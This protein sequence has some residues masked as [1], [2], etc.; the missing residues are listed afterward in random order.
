[1][2][3]INN[4]VTATSAPVR[5]DVVLLCRSCGPAL[6]VMAVATDDSGAAEALLLQY[7]APDTA[8]TA[9]TTTSG[10]VTSESAA[11]NTPPAAVKDAA[12]TSVDTPPEPPQPQLYEPV[13]VW[14]GADRGSLVERHCCH[15]G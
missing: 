7:T 6:P 2:A 10:T 9:A 15:N 12:T 4:L 14:A 8:T 3:H 5:T 13:T 11:A 1:M